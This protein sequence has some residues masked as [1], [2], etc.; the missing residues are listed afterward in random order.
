MR[1]SRVY[2]SYGEYRHQCGGR[3]EN[4][5][6]LCDEE[7]GERSKEV[8]LSAQNT[9]QLLVINTS[10]LYSVRYVT[11]YVMLWVNSFSDHTLCFETLMIVQFIKNFLSVVEI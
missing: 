7:S 6:L 9:E 2:V 11:C 4:L 3:R 1:S 10:F 8:G 5:G